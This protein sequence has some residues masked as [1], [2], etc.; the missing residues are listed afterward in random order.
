MAVLPFIPGINISVLVDGEPA[1]E[2]IPVPEDFPPLIDATG[3]QDIAHNQCFIRSLDNTSH[4]IRFRI[5]SDFTFPRD[6]TTLIISTY[7]DGEPFDN[8]VVQKKALVSTTRGNKEYV[9]FM[10]YCHRGYADGSSE[11]YEA[12]FRDIRNPA[13]QADDGSG[14]SDAES[15]KALGS[16]QVSIKVARDCGPGMMGNDEFNDDKR[17][18]SL[19]IDSDA[20]QEHGSGQIHGTTY[21]RTAETLDMDYLAVDREAH[22]G[23]FFF[24][25]QAPPAEGAWFNLQ[26]KFQDDNADKMVHLRSNPNRAPR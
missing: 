14:I 7:I 20:L 15:I 2:H 25:Y 18:A 26:K 12:F 11:S 17:N 1:T 10:T 24:Y 22:I 16:I 13:Y 4:A 6:K 23:N 21:T 19:A 9:G 3:H 5:S 8:R